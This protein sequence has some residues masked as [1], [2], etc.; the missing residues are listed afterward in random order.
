M[1]I[2]ETIVEWIFMIRLTLAPT[3]LGGLIAGYVYL[4]AR[5]ALQEYLAYA[6]AAVGLALGV[7]L[8]IRVK[9]K[10]TAVEFLS[11]VNAS[12]ELD[13]KDEGG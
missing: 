11:R 9:K 1:K 4:T 12:P 8:V 2:I 13:K 6:I 10:K 3:L 7:L 5:T